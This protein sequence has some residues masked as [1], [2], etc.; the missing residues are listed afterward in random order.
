VQ[1][2]WTG[3]DRGRVGKTNKKKTPKQE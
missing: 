2:R 3:G 1:M